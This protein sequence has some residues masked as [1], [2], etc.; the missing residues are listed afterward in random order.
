[1]QQSSLNYDKLLK[2]ITGAMKSLERDK[3]LKRELSR[4]SRQVGAVESAANE[5]TKLTSVVDEKSFDQKVKLLKA[6]QTACEKAGKDVKELDKAVK[7]PLLAEL[8]DSLEEL[9]TKVKKDTDA[10]DKWFTK[11]S[12]PDEC[13]IKVPRG[14]TNMIE[15]VDTGGKIELTDDQSFDATITLSYKG[16][17]NLGDVLGKNDREFIGEIGRALTPLKKEVARA[18]K[19]WN[20]ELEECLEKYDK[21]AA[22]KLFKTINKWFLK[23]L[24][25]LATPLLKEAT[26]KAVNDVCAQTPGFKDA[27]GKVTI[28]VQYK[29]DNLAELVLDFPNN[30]ADDVAKTATK[31]FD[32]AEKAHKGYKEA[33]TSIV[34]N[35]KVLDE[36]ID[37]LQKELNAGAKSPGGGKSKFDPA[38]RLKLMARAASDLETALKDGEQARDDLAN[39]LAPVNK[40][41]AE[42]KGAL[43]KNSTIKPADVEQLSKGLM[44][45]LKE[46]QDPI[47]KQLKALDVSVTEAK[48]VQ[49]KVG[50]LGG[51]DK[52]APAPDAQK[53]ALD[54]L[55][56]AKTAFSIK[57]VDL[58]KKLKIT[59]DLDKLKDITDDL[60][61]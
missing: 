41:I 28:D 7:K 45:T 19:L 21:Q 9:K 33:V 37:E 17:P 36:S 13:E 6:L 58:E 44:T 47:K 56:K 8:A 5:V 29:N 49:K 61:S 38:D 16:V 40:K 32:S 34:K 14:V 53:K 4:V 35:Y 1:M 26:Q 30:P 42:S 24:E 11:S 31:S 12:K 51:G 10:F 25:E 59:A 3:E 15:L 22:E 46:L 60:T 43:K 27:A 50:E 39:H 54:A 57:S 20:T 52:S 18:F 48:E 55:K 23:D 2:S